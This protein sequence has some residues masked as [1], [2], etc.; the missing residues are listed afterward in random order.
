MAENNVDLSEEELSRF[1]CL[2]FGYASNLSPV[3]MKQRCPDS[4]YVGLA[5]LD[6]WKWIINST[7]FANIIPSEHDVV[8]GNLFFLSRRDEK[9]LDISEGVPWLYR[10]LE[11]DVVRLSGDH[12]KDKAATEPKVKAMSYIDVE[13]VTEGSIEPDYVVWVNKAVQH[14]IECGIPEDYFVKYIRPFASEQEHPPITMIRTQMRKDPTQQTA[15]EEAFFSKM[16]S[17]DSNKSLPEFVLPADWRSAGAQI[18][19]RP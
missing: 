1:T 4:L 13:R 5:R 9:A 12:E 8:Y 16:H 14:G 18:Y 2:Y 7:N 17:S 15:R 6:G 3:T 11:I 10:K 19:D